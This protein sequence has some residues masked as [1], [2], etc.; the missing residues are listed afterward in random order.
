MMADISC[1]DV[2]A[3]NDA[4]DADNSAAAPESKMLVPTNA[5][6]MSVLKKVFP[7]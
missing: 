1:I 2:Y 3:D 4:N 5:V 6:I 7:E